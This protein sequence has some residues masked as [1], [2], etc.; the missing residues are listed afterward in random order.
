MSFQFTTAN[1]ILNYNWQ[2]N[3]S[4]DSWFN[5]S[6]DPP[7]FR[8]SWR[9]RVNI[10]GGRSC[11]LPLFPRRYIYSSDMADVDPVQLSE[12]WAKTLKVRRDPVKIMKSLTHSFVF[13]VVLAREEEVEGTQTKIVGVGRLISDGAFIATICDVAV[14]PAY[15]RRGIGRKIVKYLVKATKKMD[16]P[17]GFAAFP[18]PLARRFFWMIGFRYDKKFYFMVYQGNFLDNRDAISL[19]S[20][21]KHCI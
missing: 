16:G 5:G 6:T 10:S 4:S 8:I 9:T 20:D 7:K 1:T 17:S 3:W 12:L 18:P 11:V 13:V 2:R 15:Q 21:T 19:D 14:D